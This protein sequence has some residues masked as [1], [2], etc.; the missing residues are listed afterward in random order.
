MSY[1]SVAWTKLWQNPV[2]WLGG[3]VVAAAVSSVT[4]GLLAGPMIVGLLRAVDREERDGTP[5]GLDAWFQGFDAFGPAL[6]VSLLSALAIGVLSICCIVP[7]LLVAPV[8][9]PALWLV[10]RGETDPVRAL[11]TAWEKVSPRMV[12]LA[13]VH[14][15]LAFA[16]ASGAVL[17][18]VGEVVTIPWAFVGGVAVAREIVGAPAASLSWGSPS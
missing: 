14:L 3:L 1:L 12:E 8:Q 4:F 15:L 18:G 2:L 5:G 9:L 6:V 7:G 13:F 11:T 17:C 10:A 16:A